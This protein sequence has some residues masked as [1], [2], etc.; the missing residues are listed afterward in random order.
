MALQLFTDNSFLPYNKWIIIGFEAA[1]MIILAIVTSDGYHIVSRIRRVVAT[2]LISCISVINI[3]SLAFL[4]RELLF[5]GTFNGS[6]QALLASALTIYA[7]NIFMF[8]L[9]YWEFDG[10]G[11]DRRV[12]TERQ[13]DFLFPQMIHNLPG[14]SN[15]K[16]GFIDYLYLSTTNV[17]NFASADTVPVSHRA[18]LLM[19]V[20]AIVAVVTIV[21]VAARAVGVLV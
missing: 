16:P 15:W 20:Q 4:V 6:G 3:F 9:L 17:T 7:T 18:K 12:V 14:A 11:P 1:L 2:V 13:R 21:L 19:M 10:G 5:T 8:A